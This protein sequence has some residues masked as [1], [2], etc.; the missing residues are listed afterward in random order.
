LTPVQR[1]RMGTAEVARFEQKVKAVT[2]TVSSQAQVPFVAAANWDR[3]RFVPGPDLVV[4]ETL[5]A[6]A[7]DAFLQLTLDSRLPSAQGP[8]TPQ[9]AQTFTIHLPETFFVSGFRCQ[10]QCDA[11][12]YNYLRLRASAR[13]AA[14]RQ[15]TT[16]RDLTDAAAGVPV[17][18]ATP[19]PRNGD[20]ATSYVNLEDLGYERQPPARTF[21]VTI[22]DGLV[23]SDGQT[24]GYTWSEVVENW[25]ARAFTSFGDGHGVWETGGGALPFYGRN[26]RDVTQWATTITPKE[27]MPLILRLQERE[28]GIPPA[29]AGV[30]RTLTLTP[31]AIQSHGLDL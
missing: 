19:D 21:A 11:D 1:Q 20:D 29:S 3:A 22:D 18:P 17:A 13:I 8:A 4:L 24:L 7:P 2:A 28:F 31:D 9:A 5:T 26:F 27:L 15:A 16:V 12:A 14:I 6:P 25:H 23:A 10:S 30:R